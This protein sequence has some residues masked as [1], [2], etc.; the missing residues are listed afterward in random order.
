M[1]LWWNRR[2]HYFIKFQKLRIMIIRLTVVYM[3]NLPSLS[4][5]DPTNNYYSFDCLIML[6]C[7]TQDI[8]SEQWMLEYVNGLPAIHSNTFM[9]W[10]LAIYSHHGL[11][12]TTYL[13]FQV[14]IKTQLVRWRITLFIE[15]RSYFWS[16]SAGNSYDD[17]PLLSLAPIKSSSY[18][19]FRY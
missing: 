17:G 11:S 5:S 7:S 16:P 15:S 4:A 13:Q 10:R 1:L 2:L 14:L 8:L 6:V 12:T 19:E 9:Y 3:T 18:S